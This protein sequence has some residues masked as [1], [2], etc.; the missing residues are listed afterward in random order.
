MVAHFLNNDPFPYVR[1]SISIRSWKTEALALLDTGFTGDV[2]IPVDAL[3]DDIGNPDSVRRYRVAD[4]R[5]TTAVAFYGELEIQ[6][7]APITNATI[8]SMGSRYIIGRGIIEKYVVI[9]E[10]GER[11]LFEE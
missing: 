11:V 9:L 5:I 1:V 7:V 6:G 8:G 4:D 3:P 2:M 10:R